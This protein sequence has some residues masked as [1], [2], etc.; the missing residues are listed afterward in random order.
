MLEYDCV[1]LV[2]VVV[3]WTL[4]F[5][6][7]L[8]CFSVIA[9]LVLVSPSNRECPQVS[10]ATTDINTVSLRLHIERSLWSAHICT[11]S[12]TKGFT[13][14]SWWRTQ[15]GIWYWKVIF[16]AALVYL[17]ASVFCKWNTEMF[18]H[19]SREKK[20]PLEK[21]VFYVTELTSVTLKNILS[22]SSFP[23]SGYWIFE[24]TAW[25][26]FRHLVSEV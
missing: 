4:F 14:N 25:E 12:I 3:L 1:P 5:L 7:F 9:M 21:G 13:H 26:G 8:D 17:L 2:L 19:I 24:I 22:Y 20:S 10:G 6:L 11:D 23:V 16:V 15:I 18:A